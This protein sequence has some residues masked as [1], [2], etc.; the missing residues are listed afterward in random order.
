[1]AARPQGTTETRSALAIC[2][3]AIGS[4]IVF[5]MFINILMLTG[6][7]FMLQV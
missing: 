7:L 3:P 2:R 1:M 4:V 5:S 6:P